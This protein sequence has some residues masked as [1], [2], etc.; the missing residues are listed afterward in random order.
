M[1]SIV[2]ALATPVELA[3][4]IGKSLR[5]ARAAHGLRQEDL[6]AQSQASLQAI[7]NLENGGKVELV[8]FLRVAKALG[9]VESILDGCQPAPQSLDEIERIEAARMQSSRVRSRARP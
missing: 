3:E 9:M 5:L 8:T 7:K 4:E 6:A 2:P 1:R